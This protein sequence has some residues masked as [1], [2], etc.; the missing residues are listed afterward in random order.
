MYFLY[1]RYANSFL[2]LSSGAMYLILRVSS[3]KLYSNEA[4][5]DEAFNIYYIALKKV[6]KNQ[7]TG[8]SHI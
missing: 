5:S 7:N 2:K 6:L 4:F 8:I 3:G 1:I